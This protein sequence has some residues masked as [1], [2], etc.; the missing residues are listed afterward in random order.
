MLVSFNDV[1]EA[2]RVRLEAK[3]RARVAAAAVLLLDRLN[4][5]TESSGNA[6]EDAAYRLAAD[7]L[8]VTPL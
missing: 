3:R 1:A 2:V 7:M 6:Q 4:E 8:E 5:L